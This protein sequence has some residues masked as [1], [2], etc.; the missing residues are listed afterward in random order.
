[1]SIARTCRRLHPAR[2]PARAPVNERFNSSSIPHY[3]DLRNRTHGV[4]SVVAASSFQFVSITADGP[5]E[6]VAAIMGSA[7][8]FNV[9]GVSA[10]RGRMF[11]ADEDVG[12]G[13]HAVVVLSHGAWKS[14]FASDS[15]AQR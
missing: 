3:F 1:M 11:T 7:N 6:I 2:D 8:Y 13:A 5:P 12:L 10:F 9:L 14:L 15:C 4:F